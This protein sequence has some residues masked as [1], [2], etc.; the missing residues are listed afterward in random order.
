[1]LSMLHQRRFLAA[2]LLVAGCQSGT[3]VAL[4]IDPG[5]SPMLPITSI[6][7]DVSLNGKPAHATLAHSNG[8]QIELPTT[9]TLQI[10]SGAPGDLSCIVTAHFDDGSSIQGSNDVAVAADKTVPLRV[11]LGQN[12]AGYDD[13]TV[14]LADGG[15]DL[16]NEDLLNVANLDQDND[17]FTPAQGDCNDHDPAVGPMAFEVPGNGIDDDCDGKIDNVAM[18]CDSTI[19]GTTALDLAHAIELCDARFLTAAALVGPSDPRARE[20]ATKLGILQ[21]VAGTRMAFIS[22]GLA[23]DESQSGFVP[24]SQGTEL[25]T[26]N[27][28]ANPKTTVPGGGNGCAQSPPAMV[29]DYTEVALT[30]RVPQNARSFSFSSRF[31]SGEFPLYVC[32]SFA[33][34]FMVLVTSQALPSETDVVVDG[35]GIVM[36]VNNALFTVCT[37]QSGNAHAQGC[38]TP[39]SALSGTG[40]E[41]GMSTVPDGGTTQLGGG[42]PWLTTTV[43]VKPSETITVRLI[44]FDEGDHIIDSSALIDALQWST[45]SVSAPS[46]K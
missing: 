42:T 7:L 8:T 39:V 9:A 36:D 30:I 13:M 16:A 15:E 10:A 32:T 45:A 21:P 11:T 25:S 26:S 5:A 37:N 29:N 46:T 12:L 40:Y 3:Y 43:P 22:N 33:D 14:P 35:N 6:D 28:M 24:P 18:P 4:E 23:L 41:S 44:I 19:A 20:A 31:F 38:M 34:Q 17:G 1:M 27:T 2:L